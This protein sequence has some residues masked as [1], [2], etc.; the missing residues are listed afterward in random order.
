MSNNW[1]LAEIEEWLDE[2]GVTNYKINDDYTVDVNGS[3]DLNKQDL[4]EIPVEFNIVKGSFSCADN[5][6]KN[7][8]NC[9]KRVEKSFYCYNNRLISLE[10]CPEYVG[11]HMDCSGG[12]NQ[13]VSLEYAPKYIKDNFLCDYNP[14]ESLDKFNTDLG[15]I[16]S[17]SGDPIAG[18]ED[19]YIEQKY[20]NKKLKIT[21]KDIQAI[22]MQEKLDKNIPNKSVQ[23]HTNKIKI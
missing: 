23:S 1:C 14:I 2:Y 9:P 15:G 18:F 13:L 11:E 12:K 19:L 21:K 7:L 16:F 6:L 3:V 10:G 5:K 4:E 20:G 22:L 17:H 8:I